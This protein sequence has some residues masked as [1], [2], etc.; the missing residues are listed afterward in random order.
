MIL[1]QQKTKDKTAAARFVRRMR[2]SLLPFVGALFCGAVFVLSL[3]SFA[4]ASSA[5]AE[6]EAN[7]APIV[8]VAFGD[9]LTSGYGLD[10][11]RIEGFAPQLQMQLTMM[12]L[13][14]TVI[15]AGNDG[16]TSADGLNRTDWILEDNPD[17]VIVELGAN[18]MLRGLPVAPMRDNLDAIVGKI[19]QSGAKILIAGMYASENNGADYQKQFRDAYTEVAKKYGVM[20]YPFFLEGVATKA[21]YNQADG[22]HPN[23]KGVRIIAQNIAPP[24]IKILNKE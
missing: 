13:N 1:Q 6:A 5:R 17:M 22:K 16:D 15:N 8:I 2:I 11:P 9:S 24:V 20:L 7:N 23:A 18:D 12:G 19:Q 4:L 3:L 21:E 10:L 14:A